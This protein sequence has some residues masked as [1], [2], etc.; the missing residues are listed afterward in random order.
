[1]KNI[2]ILINKNFEKKIEP[3]SFLFLLLSFLFGNLFGINFS[4]INWN[5]CYI[6]LIPFVLEIGNF[7]ALKVK[8]NQNHI[9]KKLFSLK[10]SKTKIK[11]ELFNYIKRGFLLGIFVEAFKV[12]S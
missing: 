5:I 7:F 6:F 11:F 4:F 1:M 9:S 10:E 8:Q 2:K 3:L 12:G